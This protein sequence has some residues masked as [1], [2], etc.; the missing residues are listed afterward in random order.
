MRGRR[1]PWYAHL[2]LILVTG[3][4]AFPLFWMVSSS[5]KSSAEIARSLPPDT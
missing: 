4:F 5:L 2:V 3:S 1:P